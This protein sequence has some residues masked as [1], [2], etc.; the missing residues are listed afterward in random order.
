MT[1]NQQEPLNLKLSR[2]TPAWAK[3]RAARRILVIVM[4]AAPTLGALVVGAAQND[5]FRLVGLPLFLLYPLCWAW[6]AG[7]TQARADL[8]DAYLDEREV[9]LRNQ[10]YMGAFK[11]LMFVIAIVFALTTLFDRSR[12][13][14]SSL[15]ALLFTF[16][17]PLP[18][19]VLAWMQPDAVAD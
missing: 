19:A 11:G 8:P 10:A 6:L 2:I 3:P 1:A 15:I 18:T 17:L 12:F 9:G 14:A 5:P 16:G 4:Y 7:A 13:S